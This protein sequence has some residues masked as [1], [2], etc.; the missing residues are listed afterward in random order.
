MPKYQDRRSIFDRYLGR[1]LSKLSRLSDLSLLTL[2][3]LLLSPAVV[4]WVLVRP[5]IWWVMISVSAFLSSFLL[6]FLALLAQTIR[7]KHDFLLR[8]NRSMETVLSLQWNDFEQ[9]VEA[10]LKIEGYE[11]TRLTADEACADGGVDI[12]ATKDGKT[13]LVQC[14]HW[15]RE[16]VGPEPVRALFGV[17]HRDHADEALFVTSGRFADVTE[18]EFKD[19]P[20]ITLLDGAGL[21]A[22]LEAANDRLPAEEEKDGGRIWT[23]AEHIVR[24]MMPQAEPSIIRV[25]KCDDCGATMVLGFSRRNAEKFWAC[26]NWRTSCKGSTVSLRPEHVEILDPG[27]GQRSRPTQR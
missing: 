27:R 11:A 6:L 12:I 24:K 18:E 20:G 19:V 8:Q 10:L 13:M 23:S 2:S 15:M 21:M 1:L 5:P 14:K 16:R 17:M 26:P 22:R 25:P 3:L 7:Y 9:F 4:L